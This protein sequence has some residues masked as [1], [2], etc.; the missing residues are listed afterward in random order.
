MSAAEGRGK[1]IIR[2]SDRINFK[3]CRQAWDY[4]SKLRRN[5]EPIR[6]PAPLDFGTAVHSGMQVYYDPNT[7]GWDR[8][9]VE[10]GALTAFAKTNWNGLTRYEELRGP[11]E[12]L[13]IEFIEREKLGLGMLKNYFAYSRE[14]DKFTPVYVEIEFE[15]PIPVPPA[16]SLPPGYQRNG[17]GDLLKLDENLDWLPVVYQ[18]R[19]DLVILDE[20]GYYWI[21]DHKTAGQI[22]ADVVTH[23][24][25]DEQMKSYVWAVQKQLGVKIKGVIYNELYKGIP[26]PP[27]MNKVQR[28]GRWYSVSQSQ[29]TSYELYLKTVKEEDTA[30]YNAGLYDEFLQ[31]LQWQGNKYFRRTQ[32]M[33]NDFE[34]EFLGYQI[35]LEAID[36]LSDPLI[37][38]NPSRFKCGYCMFRTPCLA[39]MDGSDEAFVLKEMYTNRDTPIASPFVKEPQDEDAISPAM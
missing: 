16:L 35:C 21:D 32:V 34:L 13:R 27:P 36:M 18:G 8:D 39:N 10:A 28:L 11:D 38:P 17:D 23:L 31:F 3:S 1:F 33:Y 12:L 6:L 5:F 4:G 24:E 20:N 15:V 19:I 37:Y 9:I 30:A 2:T 22:R 7:W 29:D 14:H 25:M 26:A